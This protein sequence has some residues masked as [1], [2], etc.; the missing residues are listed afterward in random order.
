M[1]RKN[2]A[3][4][5][6]LITSNFVPGVVWLAYDLLIVSLFLYKYLILHYTLAATWY[7]VCNHKHS[8]VVKLG[9]GG[10]KCRD[11]KRQPA[12]RM[13]CFR[14]AQAYRG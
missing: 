2:I 1:C 5:K 6:R 7:V 11:T 12:Q 9:S 4:T 14:A 3:G 10:T 8:R 13:L